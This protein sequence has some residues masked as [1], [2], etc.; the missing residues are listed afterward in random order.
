[1]TQDFGVALAFFKNACD[2]HEPNACEALGSLYAEGKG[3]AQA[4]AAA[5]VQL[6]LAC[7]AGIPMACEEY[8]DQLVRGLGL[9]VNR[10][11]GFGWI[12]WSCREG[13]KSACARW[14]LDH[15]CALGDLDDCQVQCNRGDAGSCFQLGKLYAEGKVVGVDHVRAEGLLEQA[16]TV[17]AASCTA[18]SV[19]VS[20]PASASA[21]VSVKP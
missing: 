21:A 8:G 20:V 17:K 1:V 18:A 15:T 19:N 13:D 5:A 2:R 7:D 3:T 10:V 11:A 16:Y 4:Y 9:D 14:K 12:D 6:K